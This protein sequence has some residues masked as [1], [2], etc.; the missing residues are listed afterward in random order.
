MLFVNGNHR[1]G[2]VG[3]ADKQFFKRNKAVNRAE[4]FGQSE[5]IAVGLPHGVESFVG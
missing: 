1:R 3:L 4:S 2:D 5:I